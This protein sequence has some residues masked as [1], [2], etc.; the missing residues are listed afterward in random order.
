MNR[1]PAPYSTGKL[2]PIDLQLSTTNDPPLVSN[3]LQRKRRPK[4]AS[5]AEKSARRE[6]KNDWE[7]SLDDRPRRRG[8][9]GIHF[10]P[11]EGV[12]L[13]FRQPNFVTE[14]ISA[15]Q[16]EMLGEDIFAAANLDSNFA[17]A[18]QRTDFFA[19]LIVQIRCDLFMH[20]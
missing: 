8:A 12:D 14:F 5:T 20:A 17:V 16:F 19:F 11:A 18:F 9:G 10:I 3:D 1:S 15:L 6:P 7:P 13:R 4:Q 2:S